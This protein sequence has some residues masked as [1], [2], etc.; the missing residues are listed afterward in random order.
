[1]RTLLTRTPYRS[2]L[3]VLTLLAPS[4]GLAQSGQSARPPALADYYALESVGSPAI[5]PDGSRIVYVH[6]RIIEDEN[7]SHSEIWMV[8][9]DGRSA[10]ARLTTPAF[11]ASNPR[12][13]PDGTLLAFSSPRP[14]GSLWFLHMD[15]PA[16]EAFQIE[17]AEGSPVFSPDNRWIAFTKPTPPPPGDPKTYRSEF[18]RTI[19]ERFEG[20][21]YDWMNYR[22]DRRGYL[23]DPRDPQAT[24]PREVYVVP[25]EGG[26]AR[27]LTHLGV[28]AQGIAWSPDS[29]SLAFT[30]DAHQR[31]EY[32]Y[33]RA[34]L[35][36]VDLEGNTRR[37][38]D[39]GYDYGSPA[40]SP[41]GRRIAVRGSA[42]L[43]MVIASGQSHG[44][45]IDLYVIPAAGGSPRNITADWDFMAGSPE[46]SD[47]D[48]I[49]FSTGIGGNT[50]LFRA[51]PDRG[52]VEQLT[53]GDRQLRGIS[54]TADFERIAYQATDPTHPGQIFTAAVNGAD[55]RQ[56]THG[57]AELLANLRLSEAERIRFPSADGTEIEGWIMRPIGFDPDAGSYPMVL[58]I[59]GGPHG[60]YG[61]SFSLHNQL[62]AAQGYFVLFTNPRGS[63]GYGENFK[64]AIWGGW[65][66]LDYQDIMAGVDYALQHYPIDA[67]RMGVTGGSYGGFMTN[68]II[69]HTQRFAAAVARASISNWMSD[70][71]TADIPRTK[72]SEFFG[73]PWEKDSRDLMIELSPLTHAGNATTPTL[74]LHGE[75]DHRVPISEAEQMYVAL[76][77]RRVPAM[78]IRYPDSYHGGWTHWRNVHSW[79]YEF[80][81]W[82]RYLRVDPNI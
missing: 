64:W 51:S 33:E 16:G 56:L 32:S 61:N 41:D 35:W 27:Q 1:M 22:F 36:V 28:D 60:A 71:G 40:W 74:F 70:Y 66:V 3:V 29:R 26:A 13:S 11:N 50:H 48:R 53:R 52:S 19:D 43:D 68:W 77:K 81:W 42:G 82:R 21:M 76:K 63:T 69:G 44:S 12:W 54:F 30:G 72:E 25:R 65:G 2:L 75:L 34:D 7:R 80:E 57:N 47:G 45:P 24:P 39:D 10:P 59:H 55:E 31:D 73:T 49:Y 67:E 79:H 8:A 18:E 9:A 46:W 5:A 14:E 17:G 62:L 20:R 6:S 4:A 37:L 58:T 78:F 23:P 15:Q 38:T